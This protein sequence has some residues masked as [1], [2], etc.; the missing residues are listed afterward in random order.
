LT[1]ILYPVIGAPPSKV[2]APHETVN[3]LIA[4]AT[5]FKRLGALGT[6]FGVWIADAE[7]ALVAVEA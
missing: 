3:L 7:F 6:T 1:D 2:E 5:A 4:S